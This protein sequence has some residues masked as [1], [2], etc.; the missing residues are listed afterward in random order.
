MGTP[1]AD[2]AHF[3]DE[4]IHNLNRVENAV[5]CLFKAQI[6]LFN[7]SLINIEKS[8]QTF[9]KNQEAIS[10]SL[11]ALT[12]ELNQHASNFSF[13]IAQTRVMQ[14]AA[15]F[16]SLYEDMHTEL[17]TLQNAILFTKRD[18]WHLKNLSPIELQKLLFS[19]NTFI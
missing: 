5:Q 3:Y 2:D 10:Q 4:S 16:E 13:M 17:M 12:Q 19:T 1:D 11:I 14:L 6:R 7:N 9:Q 18:I 8:A 15:T